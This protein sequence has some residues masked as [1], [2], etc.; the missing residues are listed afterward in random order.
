M[1]KLSA[2]LTWLF[3]ER[4]L[5]ERFAAAASCGF[6]AVEILWPYELAA[7]EIAAQ[8]RVHG[9]ELALINL[10]PGDMAKGERGFAAR[11]GDEERFAAALE[12]ALA[13]AKTCGCSRLH[14]MSGVRIDGVPLSAHEDTL[15]ANL[16][17]VAPQCAAAGITLTLEPLNAKEN[18]TYILQS[19]A[20][21][22]AILDRVAQ[23]NVALQFDFY[24]VFHTEGRAIERAHELRG[25]FAHVQIAGCPDR[26]EPDTGDLDVRAALLQ[27]D[28]DDYSGYVGLEYKPA[29]T[30]EA[31]LAWTKTYL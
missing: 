27:L 20:Q 26:H 6:R 19:T 3:T 5:R 2:N 23:P 16:T 30:T 29:T 13:Y 28:A 4:P 14:A 31:G 17:R 21:A 8:L 24:H 1:P 9:L 7:D 10:P 12:T 11:P 18:P 15:V 22:T 25:R